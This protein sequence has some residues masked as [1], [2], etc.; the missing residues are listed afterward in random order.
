MALSAANSL[1]HVES[2][3][4]LRK[5]KDPNSFGV[6]LFA[7]INAGLGYLAAIEVPWSIYPGITFPAIGGTGLL[8]GKL[9]KGEGKLIDYGVMAIDIAT[10][11]ILGNQ[12]MTKK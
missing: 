1:A 6:L 8:M 7:F 10:V 12:F 3:R 5:E 4:Q 11:C 9:I 2:Y